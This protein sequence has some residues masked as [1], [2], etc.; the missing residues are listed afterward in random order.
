MWSGSTA[1]HLSKEEAV[2]SVLRR[3]RLAAAVGGLATVFMLSACGD[4]SP[5]T[6]E[7]GVAASRTVQ[8]SGVAPPAGGRDITVACDLTEPEVVAEVFGAAAVEEPG[9]VPLTACAYRVSDDAETTV[10]LT[11]M[12]ASNLWSGI[13]ASY[14]RHRGPIRPVDGIGD[15]ALNPGDKGVNELLVVAG[16]AVFAVGVLDPTPDSGAKITELGR[17]I[18]DGLR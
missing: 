13:K 15:E 1:G 7:N 5:T 2:P 4:T 9:P 8:P 3:V 6:G 17:R 14:V 10:V 12:G 18:A 11:Y 16:K